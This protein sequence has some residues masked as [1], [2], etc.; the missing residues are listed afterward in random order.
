MGITASSEHAGR[1]G[2]NAG[3][4]VAWYFTQRLGVGGLVRYSQGNV[5]LTSPDGTT[6]SVKV[7]GLQTGAGLRVRF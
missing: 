3:A 6:Q 7:G 1:V 5:N 4:D 2:F